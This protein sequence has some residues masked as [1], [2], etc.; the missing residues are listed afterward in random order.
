MHHHQH[1]MNSAQGKN[2][3]WLPQLP[4]LP[5]FLLTSDLQ[6]TV[7]HCKDYYNY[8][9]AIQV[10]CSAH[11]MWSESH[12]GYI[13]D[14]CGKW[15]KIHYCSDSR[16]WGRSVSGLHLITEPLG[17]THCIFGGWVCT[18]N[19]LVAHFRS[20]QHLSLITTGQATHKLRKSISFG[21]G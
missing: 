6:S 20:C 18:G 3:V 19:H 2:P 13:L 21:Y 7:L 10:H 17:Q 11:V 1:A 12:N 8:A 5:W 14:F 4:W 16:M 9:Q 15:P